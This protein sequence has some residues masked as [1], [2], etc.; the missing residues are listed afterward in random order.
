LTAWQAA[1]NLFP[2]FVICSSEVDHLIRVGPQ[3]AVKNSLN[4]EQRIFSGRSGNNL[5]DQG[6]REMRKH[7]RRISEFRALGRS[8]GY[9]SAGRSRHAD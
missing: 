8:T 6:M 3:V 9:K 1:E 7:T 2:Q 4:I 5:A